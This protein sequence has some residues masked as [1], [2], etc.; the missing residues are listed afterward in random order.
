MNP[1]INPDIK[2]TDILFKQVKLKLINDNITEII[3]PQGRLFYIN[4]F[5]KNIECKRLLE[6]LVKNSSDLPFESEEWL[7]IND[8]KI[9]EFNFRN[10]NWEQEKIKIFGKQVLVPRFTSYFGN[11]PYTYSGRTHPSNPFSGELFE[12]KEKLDNFINSNNLADSGSNFKFNSLLLNWYRGGNDYMGW[13]S[14]DEKE[15]GVNPMIASIN[16][17]SKRRFLF[18]R[19]NDKKLKL[20][21]SLNEGSLLLMTGELQ[22]HWQHTLP[23]QLKVKK[24]RINLTFRK[25]I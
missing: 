25:I 19:K 21:I 24:P 22:H 9:E 10:V 20:E 12:I 13:H 1:T 15:L 2:I 8:N 16:L 4:K 6:Y 14:D 3:L 18:R 23:K 11:E 17:G 5:L 7:R